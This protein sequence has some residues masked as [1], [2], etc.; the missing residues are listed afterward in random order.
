MLFR[1]VSSGANIF[2]WLGSHLSLGFVRLKTVKIT[3]VRVP[4]PR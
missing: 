2:D 4:A 3:G 1:S